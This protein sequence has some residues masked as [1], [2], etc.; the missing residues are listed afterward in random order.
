MFA[1][2]VTWCAQCTRGRDGCVYIVGS[3]GSKRSASAIEIDA[4]K[5][6]RWYPTEDTEVKVKQTPNPSKLRASIT[7]GTVLILLAGRFRGS[8][9]VFLKALDSG[10]LLVTGPYGVNGVP[11]RRANQAYV[12][13]TSTSIDVSKVDTADINDAFFAKDSAIDRKAKQAGVDASITVSEDLKGYLKD[14]FSLKNGQYPHNMK[15]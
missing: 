11:L 15:F 14:K 3:D 2:K 5:P 7:P 10:L 8:R 13:A 1:S 4:K 9:V 12:I 6:R